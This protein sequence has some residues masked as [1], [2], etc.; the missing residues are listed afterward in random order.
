MKITVN[1][2][3]LIEVL[4]RLSRVI[5]SRSTLPILHSALVEVTSLGI[6]FNATDLDQWISVRIPG[7]VE[8]KGKGLFP[9]KKLEKAVKA[10][11][12]DKVSITIE[13]LELET[14]EHKVLLQCGKTRFETDTRSLDDYPQIPKAGSIFSF[15]M[16]PSLMVSMI[17]KTVYAVSTDLTRPALAGVLFRAEKR[18]LTLVATDGHRLS[19]V[20]NSGSINFKKSQ[21]DLIVRDITLKLLKSYADLNGSLRVHTGE[22]WVQF[23]CYDKDGDGT[24][25]ILSRLCEGPFPS[26]EKVIPQN[27]VKTCT[28]SRGDFLESVKRISV[29]SDP[30]SHMLELNV[31]KTKLILIAENSE[32][33]KASE[34]L[35]CTG[36][37]S[38]RVGYNALY[39]EQ[40]L[41]TLE[42]EEITLK[43][44][45]ADRAGLIEER[46]EDLE[47]M[48]ILMPLRLEG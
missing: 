23:C 18:K 38:F 43:M 26:F 17:E 6:K 10:F 35:E 40:A 20:M 3:E 33:G 11:T 47:H 9:V 32:T 2:K 44:E 28:L 21:K 19:A 8:K 14:T 7:T 22:Q 41:K 27:T 37:G 25:Q 1:R 30:L 16:D 29:F 24:M 48:V 39:L 5:P 31:K 46:T 45:S 42:S 4:K 13:T 12:A 36:S 15:E 34:D